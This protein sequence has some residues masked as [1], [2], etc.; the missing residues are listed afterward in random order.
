MLSSQPW[1]FH[2]ALRSAD[3][4]ERSPVLDPLERGYRNI[5]ALALR[6]DADEA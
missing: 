3:A 4:D 5:L 6:G 1:A 2:L